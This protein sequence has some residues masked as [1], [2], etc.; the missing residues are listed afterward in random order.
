MSCSPFDVRDYCLRELP[1]TER[2][3]VEAHVHGCGACRE[4]VERLRL[5]EA[6]LFALRDEEIPQRIAFVSDKI[7][8]PSP[9]R[10]A[11]DAF[12]GSTARLGFASAALLSVALI[13]FSL[14]RTAGNPAVPAVRGI[15]PASVSA[16]GIQQQIQTAVN[17][18]VA[19][20]DTRVQ[21]LEQQVAEMSQ[22]S[23]QQDKLLQ[24]VEDAYEYLDRQNRLVARA[25]FGLPTGDSK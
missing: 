17:Q 20:R 19:A 8:E 14:T 4:E 15:V 1:E 18:A 25:S 9:W 11:W 5:T 10:R 7:F 23:R 3:Q 16:A 6:A 21:H 2:R 13:V 22:R 12:W 24:R